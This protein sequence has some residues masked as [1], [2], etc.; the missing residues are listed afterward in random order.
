MAPASVVVAAADACSLADIADALESHC[1]NAAG[2]SACLPP[3]CFD[4]RGAPAAV[5]AERNEWLARALCSAL[6]PG[7]AG[8]KAPKLLLVLPPRGA[9][10]PLSSVPCIAACAA[11]L[12]AGATPEVATAAAT[13]EALRSALFRGESVHPSTVLGDAAAAFGADASQLRLLDAHPGGADAA[14]AD[15]AHWADKWLVQLMVAAV[16]DL[17]AQGKGSSLEAAHGMHALGA[18][19][20][21]QGRGGSA[22]ARAEAL[23]LLRAALRAFC[24]SPE[25]LS[26]HT[27]G[28]IGACL[29]TL[30]RAMADGG[31]NA[32][33][34]LQP[35]RGRATAAI[36]LR[37]SLCIDAAWLLAMT[38]VRLNVSFIKRA[39]PP[40]A[41]A[42][43]PAVVRYGPAAA[44]VI[45]VIIALLA[46]ARLASN[47][48]KPRR[49]Q[50][51]LKAAKAAAPPPPQ[52]VAPAPP[53]TLSVAE[54]V[55]AFD[56]A[57][58]A[59]RMAAEDAALSP[60]QAAAALRTPT[61]PR[62]A[63]LSPARSPAARASTPMSTA[64]APPARLPG[65]R[66]PSP[67]R[68]KAVARPATPA[69]TTPRSS[70]ATPAGGSASREARW[71][72]PARAHWESTPPRGVGAASSPGIIVRP[73][74]V[75]LVRL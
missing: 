53:V 7:G 72:A 22:T 43:W 51:A 68:T 10:L 71:A 60:A 56:A 46:L 4:L 39:L 5:G 12:R 21:A 25:R 8:Q 41:A 40:S 15:V 35:L 37:A 49:A 50:A 55:R 13:N 64:A 69:V 44:L 24:S 66:A 28:A 42:A 17:R 75:H 61:P 62:A 2:V 73:R 9:G 19:L 36:A 47:V 26:L 38:G 20:A 57:A 1:A 32:A 27:Q 6:A 74:V 52:A 70:P 29:D 14:L 67:T 65:A 31:A 34:A 48:A 18:A 30:A 11:A 3:L 33:K 58:V 45:H 16:A 54:A 63:N 23:A 59:A